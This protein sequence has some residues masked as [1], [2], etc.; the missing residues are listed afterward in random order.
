MQPKQQRPLKITKQQRPLKIRE[1]LNDIKPYQAGKRV[2]EVKAELELAELIKL[3]SNE[4]PLPPTRLAQRA[5]RM[6]VSQ[7]NRYPDGSSRMLVD[8]LSKRLQVPTDNI[9]IG[10]GSNELIRLL[11]QVLTEPGDELVMAKPSFVVYPLVAKIMQ[12]KAAEV[13]LTDNRHDLKALAAAVTKKTKIIFIC[14]PNNPTGT[15]VTRAEILDYIENI[16]K[17]V[18]VAFDEAYFEFVDSEDYMSALELFADYP[19]I[20]VFRTFS[21]IYGL[22]GARIGYAVAPKEIV[23]AIQK[24]REPFNVNMIAQVGAY[25]SLDC[26]TE[27]NRRA[28]DN[29][30]EKTFLEG[31]FRRLGINYAP[32]QANFIYA[33]LGKKAAEAFTQL[34]RLGIIVRTFNETDY[35]RITVGNRD[36]NRKLIG[37]LEKMSDVNGNGKG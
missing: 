21:K 18:V 35:V 34:Q 24:V 16:P 20:V 17:N 30:K 26:D 28:E 25:Y 10:N 2:S 5:M 1:L 8:K 27:I 32:S 4:S 31:E 23:G 14:N 29:L 37:A 33:N 13:P 19:N 9:I 12:A 3:S 7:L 36:E 6:A 11:A 15:I 22:A